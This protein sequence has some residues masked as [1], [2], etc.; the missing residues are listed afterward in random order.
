M[1]SLY[2]HILRLPVIRELILQSFECVAREDMAEIIVT[3]DPGAIRP[4]RLNILLSETRMDKCVM[5]DPSQK[6]ANIIM[7]MRAAIEAYRISPRINRMANLLEQ[8]LMLA[9]ANKGLAD[10]YLIIEAKNHEIEALKNKLE[11][12]LNS[13]AESILEFDSR[14]GISF[15][16]RKFFSL[17]G[18][19]SEE[20]AQ[21]NIFDMLDSESLMVLRDLMKRLAPGDFGELQGKMLKKGGE[22]ISVQGYLSTIDDGELRYELIFE[23]ITARLLLQQ[24]MKKLEEKAIVAGFSRHLSHNILNALTAAAGFIRQIKMKSEMNERTKGMWKIVEEKCALIEEIVSGYNDYTNAISLR[25]MEDISLPAFFEELSTQ[26]SRKEFEKT[27]SAYLY[28]FLEHYTLDCSFQYPGTVMKHANR[29]FLKLAF[30][31]LLKDTIRFFE[32]QT[33]LSYRVSTQQ[34]GGRFAVVLDV[35]NVTVQQQILDT[36]YQPWNHQMLSQS[37]DYWGITIA[38]VIMERHGGQ[39]HIERTATGMRVILEF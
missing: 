25:T 27:F 32:D 2:C 21:A 35:L 6:G 7:A 29:M 5:I 23:D 36:M 9:E 39:L 34:L 19:S 18:Y 24:Q 38:S 11:N 4:D 17:S 16:N 28:H 31:Y 3:D 15:A 22:I 13:A 20:T 1:S 14:G 10:L 8:N 37:F 12:I 30:C 26:I 33:P